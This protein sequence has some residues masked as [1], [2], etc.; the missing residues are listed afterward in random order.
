MCL[1]REVLENWKTVKCVEL[2]EEWKCC[3]CLE[4]IGLVEVEIHHLLVALEVELESLVF[5]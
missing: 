5:H 4:E 2:E 1:E 3:C